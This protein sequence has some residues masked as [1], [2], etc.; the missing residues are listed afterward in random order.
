MVVV[1]YMDIYICIPNCTCLQQH[2]VIFSVSNH[3]W[4]ACH[5]SNCGWY[6]LTVAP[7]TGHQ[8]CQ[9]TIGLD[10]ELSVEDRDCLTR[11]RC[12]L[13]QLMCLTFDLFASLKVISIEKCVIILGIYIICIQRS[14][15]IMHSHLTRIP[16]Q[17]DDSLNP[18][19]FNSKPIQQTEP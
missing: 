5:C 1:I 10:A 3:L 12:T 14:P 9:D 2:P 8:L 7:M 15:V 6:H 4:T 11:E 18:E 13:Y 19:F 17:G 16:M